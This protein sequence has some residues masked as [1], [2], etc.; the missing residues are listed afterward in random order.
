MKIRVGIIGV[1]NC[2]SSL[3][4]GI[5]YYGFNKGKEAVGLMHMEIGGFKASDIEV[6]LAFD[7]DKRKVGRDISEAIYQKPN[8]TKRIVDHIENSGVT[9]KMGKILDG[10]ASHMEDY[11]KDISFD[12]SNEKQP[13]KEEIVMYIKESKAEML[14]NYLPVGSENAAKFYAECA[15]EAGVGYINNMPVFIA[16]NQEW[17]N[18]FKEKNLPII[19][20]DIKSQVGATIVHRTL[21]NLF[22][23]RGVEIDRSYQLNVGGNTDFLN[24]LDRKR[25]ASKKISKTDAVQ[26]VGHL[27]ESDVNLHVGPSDFVPW[28]KDNKVCFIRIEGREFGD[29]P[30]ELELRLSVEDSPNSAGVVIDAIRCCKLALDNNVGGVLVGP[31]SYFCKHPIE[32]FE[33]SVA[34]KNVQCFIKKYQ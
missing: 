9:V 7:I 24:M 32:Q 2:A 11:S 3:I 31:S 16:S 1:G 21:V 8:C 6:V 23:E 34:L 33:D 30:I 15:L 14:I 27:K 17:A 5:T 26:S 12:L 19:G 28:L 10:V 29:I 18:K 13:T 20:D 25:L 4:Q 22:R